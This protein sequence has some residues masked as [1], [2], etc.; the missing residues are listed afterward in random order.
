MPV[1]ALTKINRLRILY[2][3]FGP[4]MTNEMKI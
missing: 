2:L 1:Q 3:E 4:D